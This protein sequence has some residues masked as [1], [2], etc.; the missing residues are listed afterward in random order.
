MTVLWN[1]EIDSV[2]AGDLTVAL[3]YLTPAR[4]VVVQ[5]VA[6]IGLRDRSTGLEHR[7]LAAILIKNQEENHG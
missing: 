7:K 3:G 1:D 5:A 2:L 6:P 4:G